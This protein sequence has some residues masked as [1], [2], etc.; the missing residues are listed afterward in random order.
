MGLAG[1]LIALA[2]WLAI[3][4]PAVAVWVAVLIFLGSSAAAEIVFRRIASEDEVRADL[5]DRVRNPPN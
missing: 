1:G 3:D 4:R 2:A 5:E